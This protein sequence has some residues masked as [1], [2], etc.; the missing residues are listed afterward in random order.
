MRGRSLRLLLPLLAPVSLAAQD[1]SGAA[2]ATITA[3]DI[4]RRIAIIA[5]DSMRGRATPSPELMQVADY[6]AGEFRRVGLKPAGDRGGFIQRYGI[7]QVQIDTAE[8]GVT[9]RD[10]ATWRAGRDVRF[11]F[12]RIVEGTASG[13]AMLVAG[14]G[15]PAALNLGQVRGAVVLAALPVAPNGTL[16]ASAGVLLAAVTRSGAAAVVALTP[17]SDSVWNL[18]GAT[19]N[20]R[21]Q[22]PAWERSAG[23]P[24]AAVRDQT[25][26]TVLAQHGVDLAAA[27]RGALAVTSLPR[28]E[29]TVAVQQRAVVRDE[30]PNVA[31][32]LEGSDPILRSEYLIYS[33]HMDHVGV[34]GGGAGCSAMGPDTIC[35]GADDDASGTIAVVEAAEAFAALRP[36]PK[37][38][39]IFLTVSGEER[40]LW[41]SEYFAAHPPV[42]IGQMVA[43]LNVDMVGRNWVDTIVAI[44]KEHSDLGATLA[45]VNAAHPEL[46]MTAI[47][48]IWPEERFYFRS[49]HY[50]FA[51]KGVPILFFFNGVHADYHRPS[52]H[53]D[54]IDAEKEARIVKLLF[55]LGLEIANAPQRPRWNPESYRQIVEGPGR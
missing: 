23:R 30:A 1:G 54:L 50:N 3:D 12:P 28:L 42:P 51:R 36:A 17:V 49:D 46:R 37:R 47:D 25:V 26:R 22:R 14:T 29:L 9:V 38:S 24:L 11:P 15:D 8:S 33:A 43:N 39:I 52:D 27:R 7:E 21:T 6:I 31:G 16:T 48:D 18:Y 34:A 53:P 41:G 4:A 40:G 45:R 19:L 10:G 13:P 32:L 20:R 44:G 2:A 5:H 35:N 55:H